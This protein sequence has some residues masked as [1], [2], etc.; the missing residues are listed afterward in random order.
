[1]INTDINEENNCT[2]CLNTIS[3]KDSVKTKC[4]HCFCSECFWTWCDKSNK[5]PNCRSDIIQRDR[6]KELEMKNLFERRNEIINQIREAYEEYDF[7]K[8]KEKEILKFIKSIEKKIILMNIKYYD[9]K[10][11]IENNKNTVNEINLYQQDNKRWI[12]IQKKKIKKEFLNSKKLWKN[13]IR[14]VH[15]ELTKKMNTTQII[16]KCDHNYEYVDISESNIF[17]EPPEFAGFQQ[18]PTDSDSES[19]YEDMPELEDVDDNSDMLNSYINQRMYPHQLRILL[20]LLEI[21]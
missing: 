11:K 3:T 1:M 18:V 16:L 20:N 5:C 21:S 6:S 13:R 4:G 7:L 2:I 14:N 19:I 9:L 12:K 8:N 10:Y 17:E 15:N